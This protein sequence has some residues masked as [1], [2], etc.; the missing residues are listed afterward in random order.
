MPVTEQRTISAADV[1]AASPDMQPTGEFYLELAMT[2]AV[3]AAVPPYG[4]RQVAGFL[5]AMLERAPIAEGEAYA[6]HRSILGALRY[7]LET[8][9]IAGALDDP[10]YAGADADLRDPTITAKERE[11]IRETRAWADGERS[12][13]GEVYRERIDD[14]LDVSA[15]DHERAAERLADT[16]REAEAWLAGATAPAAPEAD[17]AASWLA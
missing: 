10:E 2:G 4:R 1:I 13:R 6:P 16:V 14:M 8:A 12:R 9:A 5:R 11:L 3:V 7:E 17:D 15:A